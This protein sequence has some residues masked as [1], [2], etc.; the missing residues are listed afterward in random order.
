MEYLLSYGWAILIVAVVLGALFSLGIFNSLNLAPKAIPGAC[1][2]FRPNGPGSTSLINTEGVCDNELPE[3]VF[4]SK[5]VNDYMVIP[6]SD[7]PT[8]TL[9][10][11]NNLTVTA[12]V[13]VRGPPYHDVVDKEGQYGLKLDY[14]NSP[15]ACL[16]STPPGLCLE[17][18]TSNEWIGTGDRIQNGQFDHWVFLAST[19][20]YIPSAGDSNK[21]WYANG[22]FLGNEITAG[23]LSYKP[24]SLVTI[25]A[26]SP[27]YSGLP[28]NSEWFNGSIAD[29]QI[30]N[31]ALSTNELEELYLE[32]IGGVPLR[33]DNLAGWWPLNGNGND[34]SGNKNNGVVANIIYT[35]MWTSGYSTS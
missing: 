1:Q 28:E 32:G 26:I 11:Q 30:Y 24:D 7:S 33:L 25:G 27:G 9:N 3:Y 20:S 35:T 12:W 14:N 6:G 31:T 15:H 16:P 22:Q 29:V 34:Y 8:S 23:Q 2:V 13:Y 5:G 19:I 10:I 17:W 18:D 21:V 4:N